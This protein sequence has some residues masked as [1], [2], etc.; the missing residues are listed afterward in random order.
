[1]ALQYRDAKDFYIR[2]M[3]GKRALKSSCNCPRALF[4]VAVMINTLSS[5]RENS[6]LSISESLKLLAADR[7]QSPNAFIETR[8]I[9]SKAASERVLPREALLNSSI[10]V[11]AA[12]RLKSKKEISIKIRFEFLSL[13]GYK[14]F[15]R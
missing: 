14:I 12:A 5:S 6:A 15:R 13:L 2:V 4:A 3:Y 7:K 8:R 1:M 9:S 11:A 10:I